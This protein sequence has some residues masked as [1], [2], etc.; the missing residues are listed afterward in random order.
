MS[1]PARRG[2]ACSNRAGAA[3]S[4]A[5]W[6]GRRSSSPKGRAGAGVPRPRGGLAPGCRRA[7]RG[8]AGRADGRGRPL[9]LCGLLHVL[10]AGLQDPNLETRGQLRLLGSL[11][12][13]RGSSPS[14]APTQGTRRA[15]K[16]AC[17][18]ALTSLSSA[19]HHPGI[20]P[21]RS[22]HG[23]RL[24]HGQS[25]SGRA[26]GGTTRRESSSG[27]GARERKPR[28]CARARWHW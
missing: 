5:S 19:C 4:R 15:S 27:D 23:H 3:G 11:P 16:L 6:Y 12:I 1:P 7:R 9:L 20:A 28:R 22:G 13:G 10:V 17:H 24:R 21:G 26:S 14:A 18:A 25:S 8:A 2:R